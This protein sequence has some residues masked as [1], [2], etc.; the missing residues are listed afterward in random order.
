MGSH[1]C[2]G[3]NELYDQVFFNYSS[4]M[5][6]EEFI[7]GKTG[8]L[9]YVASGKSSFDLAWSLSV[10]SILKSQSHMPCANVSVTC[11]LK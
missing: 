4:L 1:F 11:R 3:E 8:I 6:V 7:M 9:V 2:R 10:T 5:Y